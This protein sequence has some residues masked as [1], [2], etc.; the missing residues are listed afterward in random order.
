MAMHGD[1]WISNFEDRTNYW[2]SIKYGGCFTSY[3]LRGDKKSLLFL[4]QKI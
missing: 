1:L 3:T 4:A 2:V